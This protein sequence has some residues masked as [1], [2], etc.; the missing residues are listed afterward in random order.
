MILSIL[1]CHLKERKLLLDRLMKRVESQIVGMP[2]EILIEADS[3]EMT[4]GAKRNILLSKATGS[5]ICFVDDDDMVCPEYCEKIITALKTNPDCTSLCGV[6][7][8]D[9]MEPRLFFHSIKNG[10]KWFEKDRHYY[11]PA[12]HL[13]AVRRDLALQVKF[14]D[15]TH[16]EDRV[17]SEKLFP[18]LK[19]EAAIDGVIYEYYA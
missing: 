18:L 4:T 14:P 9:H 5:Y 8:R 3:G 16:G 19:T 2:V 1:I 13:N 11:R 10:Q 7:Y 12:N 6:L 15:I 17:Y